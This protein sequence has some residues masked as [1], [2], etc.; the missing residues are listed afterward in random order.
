MPRLLHQR[1]QA[2]FGSKVNPNIPH[3][4]VTFDSGLADDYASVKALVQA[5][6]NV[7]RINCAHDDPDVWKRM[8]ANVRK[9]ARTT[10]HPCRVHLDLAGP[11]IRTVLLGKGKN[12]GRIKLEQ[13]EHVWLAEKNAAFNKKD[14]VIGC[15][16]PG[17]VKDLRVGDRILFDD[18]LFEAVVEKSGD[19]LASI[20]I[21]RISAAKPRLIH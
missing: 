14:K 18:G 11:K 3:L 16:L 4:M 13:N 5:G 8:V 2:L 21:S 10:G 12:K 6:M 17:V 1:A 9:A 19:L 7:A 20:R 15:T